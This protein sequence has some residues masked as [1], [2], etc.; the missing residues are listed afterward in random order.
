MVVVGPHGGAFGNMIFMQS[1]SF[2]V[3]FNGW[4]NRDNR[5]MFYALAQANALHYHYVAPEPFDFNKPHIVDIQQL[6][7]VMATVGETLET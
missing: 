1:G 3:E 2:V 6:R 7:Q 5:P 4:I